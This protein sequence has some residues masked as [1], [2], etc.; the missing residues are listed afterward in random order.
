M[1]ENLGKVYTYLPKKYRVCLLAAIAD[2]GNTEKFR[3]YG[4]NIKPYHL[5]YAKE[6]NKK[7]EFKGEN[8]RKK[9]LKI[10]KKKKKY[11][12]LRKLKFLIF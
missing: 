7:G 4:S 9:P 3:K 8:I 5:S 6:L 10:K 2:Q 1:M 11:V 12:K